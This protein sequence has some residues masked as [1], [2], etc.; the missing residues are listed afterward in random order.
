VALALAFVADGLL[1]HVRDWSAQA[2]QTAGHQWVQQLL[3]FGAW[4]YLERSNLL[5]MRQIQS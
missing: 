2:G 1:L 4:E 5:M 3:Q